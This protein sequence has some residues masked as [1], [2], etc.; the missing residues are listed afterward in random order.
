MPK[1]TI[2][3]KEKKTMKNWKEL[4]QEEYEQLKDIKTRIDWDKDKM[5]GVVNISL[6]YIN[7]ATPSC[8]SCSSSFRETLNN[9]R[10][11]YLL[12]K[13]EWELQFEAQK[14]AEEIH[15]PKANGKTKSK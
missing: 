4:T 6:Q 15:K 13:D 11:F 2:F 14:V 7:P 1:I 12:H 8:L 10:S 3:N 5:M 9:V